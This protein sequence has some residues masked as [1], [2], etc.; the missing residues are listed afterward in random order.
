MRRQGHLD[1]FDL[2]E[3]SNKVP[4]KVFSFAGISYLPVSLNRLSNF[5]RVYTIV[6]EIVQ[7]LFPKESSVPFLFTRD[8]TR[9]DSEIGRYKGW[10]FFDTNHVTK[11]NR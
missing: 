9:K 7:R 5:P 11:S 8:S 10:L 1:P 2:L 4:T 3:E 6:K